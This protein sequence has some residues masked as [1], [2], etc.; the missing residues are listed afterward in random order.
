M[1]TALDI[2]L[3][4]SKTPLHFDGKTYKIFLKGKQKIMVIH[5]KNK[6]EQIFYRNKIDGL[7]ITA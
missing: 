3:R 5:K 1:V 7:T 2:Y 4:G 6:D